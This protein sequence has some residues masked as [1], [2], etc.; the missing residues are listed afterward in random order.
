MKKFIYLALT[1]FQILS[2]QLLKAQ[3]IS[4]ER[5]VKLNEPGFYYFPNDTNQS[6]VKMESSLVISNRAGGGI[7]SGSGSGQKVYE[8]SISGKFGKTKITVNAEVFYLYVD[9]TLKNTQANWMFIKSTG[10]DDFVVIQLKEKKDERVFSIGVDVHIG[11]WGSAKSGISDKIRV[12]F[13]NKR[14]NEHIYQIS[15][16]RSLENGE[17]CIIYCGTLNDKYV[18]N[19]VFDFSIHNGR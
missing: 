4:K 2:P 1:I 16:E 11:G 17:Y 6:P 10:A 12:P 18:N 5:L 3:N 13:V 19:R 14:I 9:S 15:F 7:H 8:K